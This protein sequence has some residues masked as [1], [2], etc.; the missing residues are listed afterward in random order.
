MATI[1]PFGVGRGQTVGKRRG[2]EPPENYRPDLQRQPR[3]WSHIASPHQDGYPSCTMFRVPADTSK[4]EREKKPIFILRSNHPWKLSRFFL[5]WKLSG[6]GCWSWSF[7]T[8]RAKIVAFHF[9]M[10]E[11]KLD[12]F[13]K[14]ENFRRL[15]FEEVDVF[16]PFFFFL[17]QITHERRIMRINIALQYFSPSIHRHYRPRIEKPVVIPSLFEHAPFDTR[18]FCSKYTRTL[19]ARICGDD[20]SNI[21][22]G[23]IA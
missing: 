9:A 22:G 5:K 18:A 10:Y 23:E 14:L 7:F 15:R 13:S 8:S 3:K 1:H 17:F 16:L 4:R 19:H 20:P 12:E 21:L 6:Y 11:V 2:N